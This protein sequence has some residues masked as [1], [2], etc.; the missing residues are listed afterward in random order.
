MGYEGKEIG[1]VEFAYG[2]PE[3]EFG[4]VF[5]KVNEEEIR[6]TAVP[7]L[8]PVERD[9]ERK[10]MLLEFRVETMTEEFNACADG[11]VVAA[12]EV[13]FVGCPAGKIAEEE[14]EV[15]ARRGGE[16]EGHAAMSVGNIPWVEESCVVVSVDATVVRG[17]EDEVVVARVVVGVAA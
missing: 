13:T 15:L 10:S 9:A 12:I 16:K 14:E 2:G 8:A 6:V 5:K 11:A 1:E 17:V 7:E 3:L 4:E